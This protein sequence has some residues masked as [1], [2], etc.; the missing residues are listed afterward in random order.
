MIQSDLNKLNIWGDQSGLSSSPNSSQYPLTTYFCA[1]M[2]HKHTFGQTHPHQIYL[3][4]SFFFISF[5]YLVMPS[6]YRTTHTHTHAHRNSSA[7]VILPGIY[8]LRE[9]EIEKVRSVE[10]DE[11][12]SSNGSKGWCTICVI[13]PTIFLILHQKPW[14]PAH[15]TFKFKLCFTE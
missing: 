5:F 1:T 4:H 12:D 7:T 2:M 10:H 6:A 15:M 14:H 3:Y 11:G 13:P 9:E 8:I